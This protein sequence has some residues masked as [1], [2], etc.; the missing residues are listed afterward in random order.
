MVG[1]GALN[2]VLAVLAEFETLGAATAAVALAA[3]A[4]F[5]D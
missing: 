3:G 1:A 2:P 4:E 5:M